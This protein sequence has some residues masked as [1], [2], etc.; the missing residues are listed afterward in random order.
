ML[1]ASKDKQT[2]SLGLSSRSGLS[3]VGWKLLVAEDRRLILKNLRLI[4]VLAAL[5]VPLFSL[6]DFFAYPEHIYL[7]G[8]FR[9]ICSAI[10]LGILAVVNSRFGKRYFRVLTVILPLVPAAFIAGMI[11]VAQDPATPYY[12][13]LSLCIVA[14]GFLFHWT[15][16]EAFIVCTSVLIFYLVSCSTA[17][18]LGMD[19]TTAAGFTSNALFLSAKGFVIVC[20]SVAHHNVRI[21]EFKGREKMRL[22]KIAL[23]QNA[24][25]LKETLDELNHTENQLIQSEKMASLGQLSAGVIH[26]I[27]NPLNYSNQALFLL[28][29]RLKRQEADGQM[30]EAVDD[31]Q[32]SIDRMKE[33]VTELREFSHKSSEVQ[34]EFN[35]REPVDVALRM[36]GAEIAETSTKV[37][38]IMEDEL[39]VE[40]VKNQ[41]T[42]VCINLIHNSIQAMVKAERQGQN[43]IEIRGL[44]D[45]GQVMLLVRDNGPGISEKIR[46]E[47]F[48]PFFTTKEAGEGTGLGLSICFR[49]I[50]AH[51]GTM[52]VNSE[53]GEFTEFIIT[54]PMNP[55]SRKRADH[56]LP[57]VA[58][59]LT[60]RSPQIHE[61]AVS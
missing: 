8:W 44:V 41:I 52:A 43:E 6:V 29:K 54:F 36:L 51:R 3:D 33:I 49:I 30:M 16:R 24:E 10:I 7:F 55:V 32:D 28:R 21:Q 61:K 40:G 46:K 15:Y 2:F 13:G 9:V 59:T 60:N 53:V 27:G 26:E 45:E 38:V 19:S 42:Q 25:T 58:N 56:H 31:I 48:D 35:L 5:L 17:L 12:A 1:G 50:E 14:I 20:G 4:C 22:Q 23:R 39:R 57:A 34:I 47:I 37:K 11:F 18:I